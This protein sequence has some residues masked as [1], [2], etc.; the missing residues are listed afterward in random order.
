MF[1]NLLTN[2][3]ASLG[4]NSGPERGPKS[5]QKWNQFWNRW[6]RISEAAGSP[7]QLKCEREAKGRPQSI[8]GK[9][10][11]GIYRSLVTTSSVYS[12]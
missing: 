11:G 4:P 6:L 9:S 1:I 10:E 7:K 12:R 8:L 2:F 3:G 5:N